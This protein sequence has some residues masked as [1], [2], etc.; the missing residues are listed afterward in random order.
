MPGC[1]QDGARLYESYGRFHFCFIPLCKVRWR[2]ITGVAGLA[3]QAGMAG[4]AGMDGWLVCKPTLWHAFLS[5]VP[6]VNNPTTPPAA[7]TCADKR[8]Q[9]LLQMRQVRGPV[10]RLSTCNS[11]YEWAPPDG[12]HQLLVTAAPSLGRSYSRLVVGNS[13]PYRPLEVINHVPD[14]Q[15]IPPLLDTPLL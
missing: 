12:A 2:G 8:R 13:G 6:P 1:L 9:A 4:M 5:P 15:C 3:W 10:P 11:L 7:A 14:A